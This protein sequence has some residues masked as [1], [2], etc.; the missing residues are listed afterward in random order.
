MSNHFP[1]AT[2]MVSRQVSVRVVPALYAAVQRICERDDISL[3]D[4]V[5]ACVWFE[6]RRR[7]PACPDCQPG[8]PTPRLNKRGDCATCDGIGVVM[9]NV[10]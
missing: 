9:P 4:F 8:S 1:D 3:T 7:A 6:V 10:L 5:T 2:K